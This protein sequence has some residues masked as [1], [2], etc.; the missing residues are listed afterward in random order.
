MATL[1]VSS[2]LHD[3]LKKPRDLL[4]VSYTVRF[5]ELAAKAKHGG[6]IDIDPAVSIYSVL[7]ALLQGSLNVL[8]HVKTLESDRRKLLAVERLVMETV[9]F[10]FRVRMPFPY[11]IKVARDL[12]SECVFKSIYVAFWLTPCGSG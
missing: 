1:Y 10:N 3:T 12:H 6:E 4:M 11:V 5:P 2:K 9:S 8:T 7:L